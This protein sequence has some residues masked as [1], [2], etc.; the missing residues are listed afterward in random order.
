ME[1]TMTFDRKG[2]LLKAAH[3]PVGQLAVHPVPAS[4]GEPKGAPWPPTIDVDS[5]G[6]PVPPAKTDN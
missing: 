4:A 1:W 6:N 3:L 2:K 5:P